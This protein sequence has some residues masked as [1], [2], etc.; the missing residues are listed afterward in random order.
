MKSVV[1]SQKTYL[2]QICVGM[3]ILLP[4]L[5]S[6][7]H[8]KCIKQPELLVIQIVLAV[9]MTFIIFKCCIKVLFC[10]LILGWIPW[11][12]LS[13]LEQKLISKVNQCQWKFNDSWEFFSF[14][15]T[16]IFILVLV[17]SYFQ[18]KY[19]TQT[20][21]FKRQALIFS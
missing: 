8:R 1:W 4:V 16:F 11:E 19:H 5:I 10:F 18:T 7:K 2:L 6:D 9:K 20:G 15:K 21:K 17:S 3:E 13:S 12:T 14:R